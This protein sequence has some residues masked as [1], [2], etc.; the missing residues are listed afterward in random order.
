MKEV[1]LRR[2]LTQLGIRPLGR[3]SSKGW[4]AF[5]CPM[6]PWT[7]N[8]GTDRRASAAAHVNERDVSVWACQGCHTKGSIAR[9]AREYSQMRGIQIPGIEEDITAAESGA[10]LN[11]GEWGE[12]DRTLEPEELRVIDETMF[13][14]IY[15]PA[16]AVHEARAYL[17]WR[18]IPRA[19]AEKLELCFDED[20]KEKRIIFPVRGREGQLHGLTGRTLYDD[21]QPKIKDYF[22]LQK[23]ALIL[24]QHLWRPGLPLVIV[25]GLF[26]YAHL[27]AI[28]VADFANIGAILGSELTPEK[29]QI[30]I[31]FGM[32][33]Y[34]FVD[35][36]D[37]GKACLY[38]RL[39][40]VTKEHKLDDGGLAKLDGYVPL[41]VPRWPVWER[42]ESYRGQPVP[43]GR[44]GKEKDDPDMLTL[45]NVEKMM[46]EAWPYVRPREKKFQRK[47]D[48]G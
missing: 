33:T 18:Q 6:A 23:R 5:P 38:G 1:D 3:T 34:F 30:I 24:G 45:A 27:H 28:G 10:L 43:A 25:E 2:I 19:T 9:L 42:G 11:V 26:A 17:I 8:R 15:P 32:P 46:F 36:D 21:I 37:A 31:E 20:E 29:R 35:N 40:P 48:R 22:G 39:D 14:G 41:L 44:I 4:I 13:A 16:A 7:H 12:I 47:N